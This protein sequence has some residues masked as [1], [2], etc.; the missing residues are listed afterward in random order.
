MGKMGR[1]FL[2]LKFYI[3]LKLQAASLFQEI[4]QNEIHYALVSI[5]YAKATTAEK[6]CMVFI[7]IMR[8]N[9]D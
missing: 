7:T 9:E 5:W 3:L 8:L 1:W 2:P 4:T 6:T